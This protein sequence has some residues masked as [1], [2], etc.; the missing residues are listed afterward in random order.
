MHIKTKSR[1]KDYLLITVS[2]KQCTKHFKIPKYIKSF[3]VAAGAVISLTLVVSNVLVYTQKQALSEAR[4]ET[5]SM[6]DAFVRL[7]SKNSSLNKSLA[8]SKAERTRMSDVLAQLE[9]ISG[10]STS[11]NTPIL[12]RLNAVS[13]YFTSKELKL[14]DLNGRMVMIEER[15]TI[16]SD[17]SSS[18]QADPQS[19]SRDTD[20]TLETHLD[21]ISL[22]V[23][24][25]RVLH[26]SIPNGYPT[27]NLGTTSAFG[28]RLHPTTNE[29][30]FH[31][32][33]DLK[34]GE[35]S[36]VVAT[37]DGVIK[38][39]DYNKRSGNRILITHNYG[40][41]TRYAH[42]SKMQV[43]AGDV[44]QKGDIIGL[45]GN[46]GRSDGP[47]L[48]YEIRFLDRA[49]NPSDFLTWEF[50]DQ[51]IF[52]KVRGIQWQSLIGLINKQVSRPTLQLSQLVPE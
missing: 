17:A 8:L 18:K 25:Q 42:L 33:V 14:D 43:E 29:A 19:D 7:S 28:K 22:N 44:V 35:G 45:S 16:Q 20:S 12:D 5:V 38:Q 13:E 31:N 40:F 51:E 4:E 50:G 21:L 11:M 46:T 10:V 36:Q 23:N 48:H 24:Q 3:L 49:H 6:E 1:K 9:K 37:A 32:G 15:I 26:D 27:Q 41:E 30:S 52:T 2:D 34:A 47:Y 39:A